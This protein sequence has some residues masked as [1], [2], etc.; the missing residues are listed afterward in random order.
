M[1]EGRWKVVVLKMQVNHEMTRHRSLV[2]SVC[3][4]LNIVVC[5]KINQVERIIFDRLLERFLGAKSEV[6]SQ[7]LVF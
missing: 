6:Y 5:I 1:E 4:Y 7:I 2:P 3:E